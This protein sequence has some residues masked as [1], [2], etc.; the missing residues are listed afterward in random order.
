MSKKIDN[1]FHANIAIIMVVIG[2]AAGATVARLG[3]WDW[4]EPTLGFITFAVAA[5]TWLQTRRA[6]QRVYADLGEGDYVVALQVGRPVSEAVKK[7]FGRLDKLVEVGTVLGGETTL[8][9]PVHY[10]QIARAVYRA[11]TAGQGRNIHLVLSGPVA[12][13]ALIGQLVGLMHF[14]LTVYQFAPS[15]GT[16]EPVPRPTRDWLEH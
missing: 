5:A 4:V 6:R 3:W 8:S 10:E 16:Y 1:F 2:L 11:I 9:L 7:Q 14:Q 13:S 12:L 15:S